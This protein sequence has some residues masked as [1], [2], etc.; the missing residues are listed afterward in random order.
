M[1]ERCEHR[2]DTSIVDGDQVLRCEVLSNLDL[3][4][5][6]FQQQDFMFFLKSKKNNIPMYPVI[7]AYG[8]ATYKHCQIHH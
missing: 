5:P 2:D 6:A 7:A 8:T 1:Y 4:A 3:M